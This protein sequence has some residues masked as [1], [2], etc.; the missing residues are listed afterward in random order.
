MRM[1]KNHRNSH[2]LPVLFMLSFFIFSMSVYA[3]DDCGCDA[4]TNLIPAG[5]FEFAG[6]TLPVAY[7]TSLDPLCTCNYPD[8]TAGY[9][10][11]CVETDAYLKCSSFDN[12][13]DHTS[14]SGKFMVVD[15]FPNSDPPTATDPNIVWKYELNFPTAGDYEFSFWYRPNL[16]SYTGTLPEFDFRV[17]YSPVVSGIGGTSAVVDTWN[18]FCTTFTITDPG[19]HVIEIGQTNTGDVSN[20]YGIDDIFV[21]SCCSCEVTAD[22]TYAQAGPNTLQFTS[23][24]TSSSCTQIVSYDWNFAWLGNSNAQNPG[25]T[26]PGPGFYPVYLTVTGIANNTECSNTYV[27]EVEVPESCEGLNAMFN[28]LTATTGAIDLEN[29]STDPVLIDT[30]VYTV[31]EPG[32]PVSYQFGASSMSGTNAVFNPYWDG[33]ITPNGP[34]SYY[35]CLTVFDTDFNP[36]DPE[37]CF[38]TYCQW[39][40]VEEEEPGP[41]DVE[42]KFIFDDSAS[43]Q[44]DFFNLSTASTALQHSWSFTHLTSGN[45]FTSNNI[46]PSFIF[47]AA[48]AWSICLTEHQPAGGGECVDT[49][50]DTIN[51]DWV[52]ATLMGWVSYDCNDPFPSL[53]LAGLS[54]TDWP[55]TVSTNCSGNS[56]WLT[57]PAS[58]TLSGSGSIPLLIAQQNQ[59]D[60]ASCNLTLTSSGAPPLTINLG[61]W[62]NCQACPGT[63]NP[64]MSPLYGNTNPTVAGQLLLKPNPVS[65]EDVQIEL[66]DLTQ[67]P[68]QIQLINT[69]GQIVRSLQLK[70]ESKLLQTSMQTGDL[71]TGIYFIQVQTADGMLVEKLL[72]E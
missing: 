42:A 13:A 63:E 26:F 34:G 46:N 20:D 25:F 72:I 58:M 18:E 71:P 14:G 47:P 24:S 6:N 36:D 61:T 65:G 5:D 12:I 31:Y 52:P 33:A 19:N 53:Y 38:D 35:V 56:V 50:C 11:Y 55:V 23:T 66:R 45:N 32:S 64:E 51:I 15:G 49:Y 60:Y 41:C 2:W 1:S 43:P 16:S 8:G 30:W 62:F 59:Y 21:G 70:S 48:G 68:L 40:E 28:V 67:G 44:Y 4:T 22:Y 29:V 10:S 69:G 17:D 3:Q 39:I 54:A 27:I 7:S 9:G 37:A 57:V